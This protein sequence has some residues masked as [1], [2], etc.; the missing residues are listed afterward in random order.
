VTTDRPSIVDLLLRAATRRWPADLRAEML[1]EWSAELTALPSRWRRWRFAISLAFSPAVEEAGQPARTWREELPS[2]GRGVQHLLLIAGAALLAV[3]TGEPAQLARTALI[4]TGLDP[5]LQDFGPPDLG[6]F[7]WTANTVSVVALGLTAVAAY[8]IGRAVGRRTPITW[9]GPRSAL[10]GPAITAAVT[11]AAV[12]WFADYLEDMQVGA[13]GGTLL[14]TLDTAAG[15]AVWVIGGVAVTIAV[16]RRRNSGYRREGW[17]AAIVGGLLTLEIAAIVA[18]YRSAGAIGVPTSTAPLW[19]P[20]SL[21]DVDHSGIVF[22]TVDQGYVPSATIA[23][24]A[25]GLTRPLLAL[26][27]FLIGY[28]IHARR[29]VPASRPAPVEPERTPGW[30]RTATG[31][32]CAT[33][34]A[35]WAYLVGFVTPR[36]LAMD[37]N[38]ELHL[39][40]QELR[41]YAILLAVLGFAGRLAGRVPVALASV[42]AYAALVGTDS[43][44]DA[45]GTTGPRAVAYALLA[46]ALVTGTGWLL[47]RRIAGPGTGD[48][49]GRRAHATIAVLAALATPGAFVAMDSDPAPAALVVASYTVMV[50]LWITACTAALGSRRTPLPRLVGALLTGGPAVLL[51]VYAVDTG[52]TEP[53]QY[54]VMAGTLLVVAVSGLIRWDRSPRRLRTVGVWSALA[55]VAVPAGVALTYGQLAI[56]LLVGPA[57]M[58][59]AG[60]GF[61]AD[62][63]PFQPGVVIVGLALGLLLSRVRLAPASDPAFEEAL[64]AT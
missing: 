64:A 47:A 21:L 62:G 20:L 36:A 18:V 25:A 54:A 42:G 56:A 59:A 41:E 63:L 61:P 8:A 38:G 7:D 15:L 43:A 11:A 52:R 12:L 1:R 49:S 53:S 29:A 51:A 28:A 3:F 13:S 22:G 37:Q 31:V 39:W 16:L 33:G 4:A 24:A 55:V 57:L 44:L 5:G 32:V 27:G 23:G 40:A 9:P 50:L 14:Y 58:A 19:F 30:V 34:I 48:G 46:A 10:A 35:G 45:T 17:I 6:P 2:I 26:T 60:Y